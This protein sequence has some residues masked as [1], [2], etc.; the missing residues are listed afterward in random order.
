MKQVIDGT[1]VMK[2]RVE[3]A[4]SKPLVTAAPEMSVQQAFELMLKNNIR[5]LPILDGKKP[6]GI[7]TVDDIMRWVL[8]VSYE[9]EIPPH[10]K[11]MLE[12]R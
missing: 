10:V 3:D 7:V 5:R 9:P 8:R 1:D 2:R 11:A 6:V 4:M 12:A